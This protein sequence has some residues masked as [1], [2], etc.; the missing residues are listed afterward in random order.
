M[1][2]SKE[3]N[4]DLLNEV[5]ALSAF[6]G[7]R[8]SHPSDQWNHQMS[9]EAEGAL[10]NSDAF[11]HA[12]NAIRDDGGVHVKPNPVL[13]AMQRVVGN[14]HSTDA[15]SQATSSNGGD[16]N[17]RPPKLSHGQLDHDSLT[18]SDYTTTPPIKSIEDLPPLPE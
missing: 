17:K 10:P 2:I 15:P 1:S 5:Y 7:L 16:K 9:E 4:I 12:D 6:H 14:G 3:V 13:E 8:A 18:A 11:T